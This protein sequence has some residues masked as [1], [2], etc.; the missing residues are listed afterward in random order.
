METDD[1]RGVELISCCIECGK[2]RKFAE[3]D[4]DYSPTS[5]LFDQPI[6]YC[7]KPKIKYKTYSIKGYWNK[8][9]FYD[10]IEFL[11]QNRVLIYCWF[12]N[13]IEKNDMLK[14]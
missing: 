6:V 10:L 13:Q 9:A 14:K 7:R 2:Q 1:Y 12:W 5:Q 11:L 3:I 4:I 8:E